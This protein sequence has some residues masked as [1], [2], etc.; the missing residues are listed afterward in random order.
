MEFALSPR[1]EELREKLTQFMDDH[2]CA[3][4]AVYESQL[5]AGPSGGHPPIMEELK[6]E[7]RRRGLWNLFLP[8]K[9][10]W[11]DG[12]SNV[13]YAPLAEIMGR[14]WIP[15]RHTQCSAPEHADTGT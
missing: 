9:T 12:L 13:D 6:A 5:S 10:Q 3:A 2:V 4:E 15:Y 14:V 11:T 7:A 8:H 1:C